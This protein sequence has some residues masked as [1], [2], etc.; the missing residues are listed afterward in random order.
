[1]T[2]FAQDIYLRLKQSK[3]FKD[4]FWA[5][6]GNGIGYGLLLL[7]GIIIA[8]M[9]GK[10]VYGEYGVVKTTMMYMAS[11][12]ALGFGN[13]STRYIARFIAARKP[14]ITTVIRD[15]SLI[16]LLSSSLIAV[17]IIAC[18]NPLADYLKEPSLALSFRAL[19]VIIV[20]KALSTTG[21]G[22]LAGFEAFKQI[23]ICNVISGIV[24]LALCVPLTYAWGLAGSL[25][26]LLASQIVL[27]IG[28]YIQIRREKHRLPPQEDVSLWRELLSFT[29][30]IA[31]QESSYTICN[32]GA[33]LLL[34][35]LSSVG[36]VGL[37]TAATQWNAIILFIPGILTNVI[38]S[39]LSGAGD[40][41]DSHKHTIKTMLCVNVACTLVPFV[42]VYIATPLIVSFYGSTFSTLGPLMRVAVF[43]SIIEACNNVF[44]SEL[45][46]WGRNWLSFAVRLTRDIIILVLTWLIVTRHNG[47]NASMDFTVINLVTSAAYLVCVAV[48]C[49]TYKPLANKKA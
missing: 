16:T 43:I 19:A 18:A 31:L 7:A 4:S 14:Y 22:I 33:I 5:V 1:M 39:H 41:M 3:L 10:D 42:I 49:A 27:T 17:V 13:T 26:A 45:L 28:V 47:F 20:C 23:G 30:P 6:T 15:A 38:L 34:T 21:I 25:A 8:R 37:Y 11:F 35:S 32:W 9:L 44:K 40:N 36:E 24:M 48:L 2:K 29:F 46:S 12:A